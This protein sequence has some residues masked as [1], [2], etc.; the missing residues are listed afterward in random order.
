MGSTT[1][2][3]RMDD[4]SQNKFIVPKIFRQ[5]VVALLRKDGKDH[6]DASKSRYD[7]TLPPIE[8]FVT[9]NLSKEDRSRRFYQLLQEGDLLFCSV[10]M[11]N[12]SGLFLNVLCYASEA[13]KSRVLHDL[14]LK[15][16][17]PA[18]EVVPAGSGSLFQQVRSPCLVIPIVCL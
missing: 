15:C 12:A 6:S 16:F 10:A 13:G 5:K 17:C 8:A 7:A 4:L 3:I 1:N 18:A 2:S 11:K 9:K 14:D